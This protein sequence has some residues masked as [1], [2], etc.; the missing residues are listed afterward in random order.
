MMPNTLKMQH[1]LMLLL[2]LLFN[3][4]KHAQLEQATQLY[5]C[6]IRFVTSAG[7]WPEITD[8]GVKWITFF[9][10]AKIKQQI[11]LFNG[12]SENTNGGWRAMSNLNVNKQI[13]T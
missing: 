9:I 11:Y 3:Y 1:T 13:G 10:F 6:R 2:A 8:L 7:N 12:K 5:S 4:T